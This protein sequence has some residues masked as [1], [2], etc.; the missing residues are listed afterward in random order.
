MVEKT[1]QLEI[2]TPAQTAIINF[3]YYRDD[4]DE[5]TL[6]KRNTQLSNRISNEGFAQILTTKLHGKT[7]LRMCTISPETTFED[8]DKTIDHISHCI[9]QLENN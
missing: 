3:R 7:V 9:A 4:L 8:I 1:P 2:V 5:E 6:N